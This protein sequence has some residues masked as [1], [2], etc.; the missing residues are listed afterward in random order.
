MIKSRL[1]SGVAPTSQTDCAA[2]HI[3]FSYLQ[4][5]PL[6]AVYAARLKKVLISAM[7]SRFVLAAEGEK[8]LITAEWRFNLLTPAVHRRLACA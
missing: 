8:R 4:R 1:I 5:F 6:K 7:I 3:A 2:P